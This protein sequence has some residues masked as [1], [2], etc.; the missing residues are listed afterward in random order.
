MLT[1]HASRKSPPS[2]TVSAPNTSSVTSNR[3][4]STLDTWLTPRTLKR[5]SYGP[6]TVHSPSQPRRQTLFSPLRSAMS[7]RRSSRIAACL[8]KSTCTAELSMDLRFVVIWA[9]RSPSMQRRMRFCRLCSGSRSTFKLFAWMLK[10]RLG[11]EVRSLD[12]RRVYKHRNLNNIYM[13][14]FFS[15]VKMQGPLQCC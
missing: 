15:S 14:P 6:L 10:A 8:T 3:A 2:A 1:Q 4:K 9:T 13:I 7:P 12:R 5:T 11:V